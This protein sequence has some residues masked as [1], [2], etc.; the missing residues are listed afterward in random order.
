MIFDKDRQRLELVKEKIERYL[1]EHLSLSLRDDVRLKANKVGLDFL[2]YIIKPSH[3]LVRKRVVN[4][5]KYKKDLF[6]D[7]Y[8]SNKGQM[9]LEEIKQFLSVQASFLAHIKWANSYRL[10][11]KIGVIDEE[12]YITKFSTCWSS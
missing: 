4:N 7:K 8:E 10:K 2:G 3:T 11:Q 12:R 5:F 6:L 1:Y 9:S